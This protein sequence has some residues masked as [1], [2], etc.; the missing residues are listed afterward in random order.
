M[1]DQG[2][3]KHTATEGLSAASLAVLEMLPWYVN[4]TLS[5]A[6]RA[7]VEAQVAVCEVC[8]AELRLE[9]QIAEV[10]AEESIDEIDARASWSA[11]AARVGEDEDDGADDVEG[12][13]ADDRAEAVAGPVG[14][15]AP[16]RPAEGRGASATVT[17]LRPRNLITRAFSTRGLGAGAVTLLAA[18]IAGVIWWQPTGEVDPSG[19]AAGPGFVTLTTPSTVEGPSVRVMVAEGVTIDT[20][21]ARAEM[22]GLVIAD[23]PSSSGVYTMTGPSVAALEGAAAALAEDEAFRFVT[24]R[25][26]E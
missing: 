22:H 18:M 14:G 12:A 7:E 1:S 10:V 13:I 17:R 15:G 9:R 11:I 3:G 23:G 16:I 4:G 8:A 25:T 19:T 21:R 5:E 24:I 20:V 26:Q 6:E 2:H